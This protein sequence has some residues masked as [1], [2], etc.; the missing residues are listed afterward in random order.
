MTT[1]ILIIED[2]L[3]NRELMC[4]LL[5]AFGY[6]PLTAADGDTGIEMVKRESPALVIC[7]IHLPKMDG[8]QVAQ[9]LK[10]DSV[11]QVI[12][13][14][15][16]TALAMVGD[17]DKVLKAGFDG[18]ITKP[19]DPETFM[20]QIEA[21]LEPS[22][23][24][25]PQPKPKNDSKTVENPPDSLPKIAT[26]LVLDNSEVNRELLMSTLQ[27]SGY[28]VVLATTVQEAF[29]HAQAAPPDLIVS[30]MHMPNHSGL[31]FLRM[32]K[33]DSDLKF[34]PFIFL[35]SS[36]WGESE[37]SSAESMGATRFIVRPIEPKA[38]LA[39]IATCLKERPQSP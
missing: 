27:P 20:A 5:T 39:E 3:T 12:P 6:L 8:Y 30:D 17:N 25:H 34:I 19:I 32:V 18:Y 2:N 24:M 21:F 1:R 28:A 37:R 4:Y 35:T 11:L 36:V 38:L 31:D 29:S 33:A 26:L 14:I 13:L 23:R 15:A 7:D 9:Y 10:S 16:V 22:Q